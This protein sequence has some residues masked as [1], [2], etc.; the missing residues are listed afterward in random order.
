LVDG[1]ILNEAQIQGSG[2][3]SIHDLN[4][5]NKEMRIEVIAISALGVYFVIMDVV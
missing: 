1:E 3:S 5:R 2:S 4:S